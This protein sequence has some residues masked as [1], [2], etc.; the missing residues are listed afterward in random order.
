MV[1]CRQ[2]QKRYHC[3]EIKSFH[4][5][6]VDDERSSHRRRQVVASGLRILVQQ[7]LPVPGNGNSFHACWQ[8]GFC[9]GCY[10]LTIVGNFPYDLIGFAFDSYLLTVFF[11]LQLQE[12][13]WLPPGDP[14]LPQTGA[15]WPQLGGW[16]GR[17]GSWTPSRGASSHANR[18]RRDE[19]WGCSIL[20]L[21]YTSCKVSN[22]WLKRFP[23][24]RGDSK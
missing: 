11:S 18:L 14:W 20:P 19:P 6:S 7:R 21:Q 24:V 4:A 10:W 1:H 13:Q 2:S 15:H 5:F 3:A 8:V 16:T 9:R 12:D 17:G 23:L 22:H